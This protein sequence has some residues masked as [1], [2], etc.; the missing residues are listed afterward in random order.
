MRAIRTYPTKNPNTVCIYVMSMLLTMPGTET[1]VTPDNEV[2]IIP[3]ETIY[4]GELWLPM[5]K[6]SFP[7]LFRPVIQAISSNSPK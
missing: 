2:P 4:H 5:K 3:M 7:L 6:A 1:K